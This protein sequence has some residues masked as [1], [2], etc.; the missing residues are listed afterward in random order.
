MIKRY[1]ETWED[2]EQT[3]KIIVESPAGEYVRIDDIRA[4]ILALNHQEYYDLEYQ[5]AI[6]ELSHLI[7]G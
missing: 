4:F 3:V 2:I 6:Q 1:T 7:G 5:E